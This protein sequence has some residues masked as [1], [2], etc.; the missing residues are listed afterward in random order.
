[1][2][3]WLM[4]ENEAI[5]ECGLEEMNMYQQRSEGSDQMCGTRASGAGIEPQF[6][7]FL[8]SVHYLTEKS[9]SEG[10]YWSV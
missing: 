5:S 4:T 1:M 8:I 6:F 3:T 9:V 7:L 2:R 10:G